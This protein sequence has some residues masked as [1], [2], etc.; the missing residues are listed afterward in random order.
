VKIYYTGTEAEW[1]QIEDGVFLKLYDAYYVDS[2]GNTVLVEGEWF[3]VY[4]AGE[5]E[6]SE[7]GIARSK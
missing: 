2:Q 1:E 7:D 3:E 6:Y 4:H 5:W